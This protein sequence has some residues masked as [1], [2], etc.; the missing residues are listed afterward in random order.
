MFAQRF[1]R[2]GLAA[3]AVSAC[4]LACVV[5]Q[6]PTAWALIKGEA[7]TM[8]FQVRNS[9]VILRGTC[10]DT[11]TGWFNKHLVT[12][13][14]IAVRKYVKVP[15]KMSLATHPVIYVS[16]L[17]GRV[18]SPL[19]LD[20][21]YPEM[22]AMYK[23]EEVVLF[24]QLPE[25]LPQGML[26]RYQEYLQQGKLKPT[27]LMSNFRLTTLNISKLTVVTDPQTG[28]Q[29]VTRAGLDRL[30]ITPTGEMVQRYVNALQ[31]QT[32][33]MEVVKGGQTVRVP[34]P[35]SLPVVGGATTGTVEQRVQQMTGY[36]NT[37]E[38]FEQQVLSLQN[39]KPAPPAPAFP[40]V[41]PVP[42]A[43]RTVQPR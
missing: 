24:L 8:D 31:S 22:A 5:S 26:A 7:V 4:M 30:G 20:E 34:V 3:M 21:S 32:G 29:V 16:Q 27:P 38:T 14:K 15:A 35:T 6:T 33:Y 11:T 2:S 13:Y 28:R 23:G 39:S 25:N 10:M 43:I 1:P 36:V 17:G 19:P 41:G 37:W 12:T 18:E 42:Q 9:D 40:G